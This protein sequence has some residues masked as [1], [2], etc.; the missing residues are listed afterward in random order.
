MN[1]EQLI[2]HVLKFKYGGM[3]PEELSHI[4]DLCIDKDVLELGS[5]VGM[6]SYVIASVAKNLSCVDAWNDSFD[7]LNHSEK[8]LNVY[9]NDWLNQPTPPNMYESFIKNCEPFINSNKIKMYKGTTDEMCNKFPNDS[10]DVLL[11]D[12]DH[13]FAGVL[14]D[15]INYSHVV[16]EN[17]IIVFHDYEPIGYWRG[18]SEACDKMINEGK[19]KMIS[20]FERVAVTQ[21]I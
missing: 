21:K 10:F 13:E 19:L 6:S 16:R 4:Y 17:G 2:E 20:L 1:K 8:Q 5:M 11:I 12:A 15:I 14:K 3:S 7:H 18:V 9:K